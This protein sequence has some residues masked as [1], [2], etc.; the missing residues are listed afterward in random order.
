MF[1]TKTSM[2]RSST[3]N[4]VTRSNHSD[5]M[6]TYTIFPIEPPISPFQLNAYKTLRLTSL[7]MDP[8][9]F[10][11]TYARE[12]AFSED[13]WRERLDS[14]F[15]Q[16]M[17]AS[18]QDSVSP[19]SERGVDDKEKATE[20]GEWI[21]TATIVGPSGIL[22]SIL[23]PFKEA[24]VGTNWEM[25]ALFAMWVHPAHRGKGVGV[26]L[27][28]ACLEWVRTNVDIKFSSEN[29]GDFEKVAVLLVYE[30]NVAGRA[31]YSRVGFSDLDG[32]PTKEGERWMVA[33]V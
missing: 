9:A 18:V 13:I 8:Q 24:G 33:R 15:K 16:T 12:V 3:E 31:L 21:G 11:S 5:E 6:P 29:S 4:N 17:V 1:T 23:A 7:Q 22:P 14:R 19:T 25:Y 32:V 20:T 30:D 27:V 26:Q 28:K 10:A 2:D